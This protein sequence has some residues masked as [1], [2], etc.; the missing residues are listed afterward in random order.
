MSRQVLRRQDPGCPKHPVPEPTDGISVHSAVWDAL[1][2]GLNVSSAV[3]AVAPY[4]P[5]FAGIA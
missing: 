3:G 2:H 4:L 5:V 1:H